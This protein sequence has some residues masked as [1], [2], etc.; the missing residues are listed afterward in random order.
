MRK[1]DISRFGDTINHKFLNRKPSKNKGIR[2]LLSSFSILWRLFIS[3]VAITFLTSGIVLVS[4]NSYKSTILENDIAL[5]ITASKM[6]LTSF[7]YVN[8]EKGEPEEYDK[9][10]NTENRVWIDFKDIPKNMKNAIVAIEDKRFYDHKGIDWFRTMGAAGN[11]LKG[12]AS[13]GGSTLT[14]QL[15]KNITEDNQPSLTRKLREIFRAGELEKRYSK[16]EILE[17]Y[18]NVVNFG[19]GNRGVQAA[20]NSYFNKNIQDCSL[21]QCAAIAGI[22]QNP[23]AYNPL[24]HPE[25]NKSRREIVLKEMLEQEKISQDEY[26][27][28]K[29]ES[30]N[31][32]FEES[33][34]NSSQNN[35]TQNTRNWY[36][37]VLLKDVINDLCEK[38]NIGKSTAEDMIYK[39][40]LKIYSAMDVKAQ[41][42]A[43]DSLKNSSVMPGDKNLELGYIMMGLDGRILATIG[44]RKEKT[45]NLLYD[46][47]CSAKRQPG[48][49]IK[50][51]SAY[52]PAIDCGMY[53]YSSLIP[54]EPLQVETGH[55]VKNWPDNWYKSYKGKVTLQWAIEKSANAPVAQVIKALT[56]AKSYDFLT[57]KLKINSL[58]SSDAVSL[59]ALATG[60]THYGVTPREMTNAFQIF[61]NGGKFRKSY[62]Y[63]YVT[64]RNDK[65]ILDNRES[66]AEQVITPTTANIMNRLLRNVVIGPE[67]T[68]RSANI[69]GWEIV[70]KTGTTNDDYDSWFIGMS[71][72]AVAGIWTGYDNPK[73]IRDT[74]AAIRIWKHIMTKYLE[75]K[76]NINFTFDKNTVTATY[77]KQ[78]GNLATS[79][80][81]STATGYYSAS[82]MPSPCGSHSGAI[83]S[84]EEEKNENSEQPQPE[85]EEKKPAESTES[86]K[87]E[88]KPNEQ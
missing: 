79:F 34:N 64:D 9:V 12:T 7:V 75:G 71:P 26:N 1:T 32:K 65:V 41:K 30:D 51:I 48:S 11:L 36:M 38:Y 46:R 16:D 2:I 67:G 4:L 5:N 37:E 13:Y 76:Q 55:G 50:P 87:K 3:I 78:S 21:A 6:S 69:P 85:K 20:A 83:Q 68:G 80:C 40:G 82:A 81:P 47:A 59:A 54:D 45:G 17:S 77:C 28:A 25:K 86:T 10:Y 39:Q 62:T 57:K 14:Q 8:N 42:I 35:N 63:F 73:R 24:F 72:Y 22:T 15:V 43:E 66:P 52:A 70:G 44:S 61:G 31:M 18:L 49:T 33:G 29:E 56:P 53:N 27:A 84:T 74:A 88:E 58:D 23:T 60:G 19:G